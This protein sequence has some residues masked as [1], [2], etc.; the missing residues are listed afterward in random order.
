M[1][2]DKPSSRQIEYLIELAKTCE[3]EIPDEVL[4][5][6]ELVSQW[7]DRLKEQ[8]DK[9]KLKVEITDIEP[10]DVKGVPCFKFRMY[11]SKRIPTEIRDHLKQNGQRVSL[12]EVKHL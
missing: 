8:I 7:I 10:I 9:D 1:N 6:K 5:S 11:F 3:K 12:W 4:A 2:A